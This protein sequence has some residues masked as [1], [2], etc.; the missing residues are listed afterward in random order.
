MHINHGKVHIPFYDEPHHIKRYL[1]QLIKSM[2]I[3]ITFDKVRPLN[4]SF[5]TYSETAM[6]I[7]MEQQIANSDVTRNLDRYQ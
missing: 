1:K 4:F 5:L 2:N 6:G 3:I 7:K